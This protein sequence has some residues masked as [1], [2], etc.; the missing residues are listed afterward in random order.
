[1]DASKR[2]VYKDAQFPDRRQMDN[3]VQE[4]RRRT[5]GET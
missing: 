2:I 4:K 5:F 3:I 1:M